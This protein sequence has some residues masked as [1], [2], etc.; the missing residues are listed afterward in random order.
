MMKK[1]TYKICL[2]I[3]LLMVILPQAKSQDVILQ[4]FYW[5]THPGDFTDTSNGGLWWDT[6]ATVAPKIGAA[7]FETI[8]AP[9]PQKSFAGVFDMGYGPYDY[10]DLGRFNSQGTVRTRHGNEDQLINMI[11][12]MHQNG[13]KVMADIV[14]NHRGGADEELPREVGGTTGFI[15]FN[16][17]SGR[18]FGDAGDFHPNN[19]HAD[20]NPPFHDPIFFEDICYFNNQTSLPPADAAGNPSIWYFGAPS[21][22]GEMGN[23]LITWGRFLTDSIGFDEI[24]LDA[25]KH[26]EPD[27]LSKFIL[28]LQEEQPFALG[29]FFD[30]NI[31]ELENYHSSVVN[32]TNTGGIKPPKMSLFDFPLR[33]A[34]QAVLNDPSG[35]RDL[36]NT[37]GGAGLVWGS[38]LSGSEVVTWLDTHDTDRTGFIAASEGCDITFGNACLELETLEDHNPI[39]TDKEDMGYPLLLAAEGRP[40]V[41]WKDYFWFGLSDEIDWLLSLRKATAAGGSQHIQ[42]LN[43]FWP[44][45][46]AFDFDNNGG[47]MFAMTRSGIS[48]NLTDGLVLGLNDHPTKTNGV[49][50]NTPFTNVYL[51]DYSDGFL[52]QTSQVFADGRALIQANPRD[53]SWYAPTGLYPLGVSKATSHFNLDASAGGC[54]HFVAMTAQNA[55]NYQVN[56]API[57]IGDQVAAINRSGNVVGIGRIGQGFEWNGTNDLII[58]ILGAPSANGM[59]ENEEISLVVFDASENT[60]VSIATLNYASAGISFNFNPE[61]PNT[62]NRNGNNSSIIVNTTAQGSFTCEGVS[63]LT[64]F[65]TSSTSC[66]IT[67][68]E[69]STQSACDIATNTFSQ[70]LLISFENAPDS[71]QVMVNG[72]LFA[73]TGNSIAVSLTNEANGSLVDVSIAIEGT[74]CSLFIPALISS[75]IPCN[76]TCLTSNTAADAYTDGWQSG[77][78]D[79]NGFTPWVLSTTF[80]NP[81]NGGHFVFTATDNGD[82][83]NNGDGDIDSSGRSWG[84]YA[85]S[86]DLSEARRGFIEPLQITDEFSLGFDNGFI[87]EGSAAGFGIQNAAGENLLEFFFAGGTPSYTILDN[88]GVNLT[89]IGFT[90][91]GMDI[92]FA[93]TDSASYQLT[94]TTLAD[95]IAQIFSGTLIE[96][97]DQSASQLRFFNANSGFNAP[98]NLFINALQICSPVLPPCEVSV[99]QVT[100]TCPG[101]NAGS[102]GLL[103]ENGIAPYVITINDQLTLE[104]EFPTILVDSLA[105]G[106]YNISV[107]D[108]SGCVTSIEAIIEAIDT[109][110]PNIQAELNALF[111]GRRYKVFKWQ[112]S[113]SDNCSENLEVNSTLNTPNFEGSKVIFI[114]NKW[115]SSIKYFPA[116]NKTF[117]IS[118]DPQQLWQQINDNQ[119]IPLVQGQLLIQRMGPNSDRFSYLFKNDGTLLGLVS[120]TV[121]TV[122][123][124]AT[125][126]NEN[127]SVIITQANTHIVNARTDENLDLQ[128]EIDTFENHQG[129][130]GVTTLFPNPA[131]SYINI[132]NPEMLGEKLNLTIVSQ[133]GAIV[134]QQSIQNET[135]LFKVSLE[136]IELSNGLY[137]ISLKGANG[138]FTDRI[139]IDKQ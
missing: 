47:N 72:N 101:I 89:G 25:V 102:I 95:G 38:S 61:R 29:E 118:P 67:N 30:F 55:T 116:T 49:F 33:G 124:V 14:L 13:V 91:E 70:E 86:G 131:S 3:L 19:F 4:G 106:I 62:P 66:L 64:G 126:E 56:G 31:A 17:P 75:P 45:E 108:G 85:N 23:E 79:G 46:G 36:F 2:I 93:L 78:N 111:L 97:T 52:F 6:L 40:M 24:R 73:Y 134:Y 81:S 16:P 136:G 77:D 112:S 110:V 37:L 32:S 9:P 58:E 59:I 10:F 87:D 11:N 53:Y 50:V 20:Q 90:D 84:M 135:G 133:T 22:M 113:V 123:S 99:Q 63:F 107:T 109:E 127:E 51:K 132:L 117:V 12:S 68:V 5:N 83:D 7:G 96:Q 48:D 18:L 44:Q 129:L 105:A 41:F 128:G 76:E 122:T 137:L 65:G 60:E 100:N 69:L 71:G 27:Y 103:V 42:E 125:D 39:F 15:G 120:P 94:I 28:E 138:S 139:V 21:S 114:R 54:P 74:S 34:L 8:W 35:G 82:G 98:S 43:G 104:S 121:I 80:N 130:V 119:G 115:F 26:I 92:L 1:L 57:A 88:N